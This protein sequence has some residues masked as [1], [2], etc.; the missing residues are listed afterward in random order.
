MEDP[1]SGPS[2]RTAPPAGGPRS[3]APRPRWARRPRRGV[4]ARTSGASCATGAPRGRGSRT[5]T[6]ILLVPSLINRHYVLDLH[7]GQ[8]LRR[9]PRG[10]RARRVLCIDWGT[11]TD[12]DR[13]LSSTTSAT[14]TSAAPCASTC[15][16]RGAEKAHVLGTASA[17]RSRRSTPPCGPSASPRS[18]PRGAGPLPR[19]GPALAVDQHPPSTSRAGATRL[20]QRALA[21]HAVGFQL[22]RPTL[23]LSKAAQSA[24]PRVGRRVPRR[25][26][27]PRDLGQRQRVVP[28]RGLRRSTSRPS[29]ATTRCSRGDLHALGPPRCGCE[30]TSPAPPSR[31]PSSTTTSCP[32]QSAAALIDRRLRR[33]G[34]GAH[35]PVPGGP[36]RRRGVETPRSRLCP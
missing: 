25:L 33:R 30:T 23:Q 31:S 16:A 29:T 18:R 11:P 13:Y 2:C 7:A 26:P 9:V 19:R 22:L 1:S 35:P 3:S 8:E 21:D 14:A 32:W 6:P 24:R 36:R 17:A 28:R 5:E 34:Q 4:H 20:R 15:A 12:E 27:R 10:R